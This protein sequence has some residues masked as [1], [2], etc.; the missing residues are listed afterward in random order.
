MKKHV[1]LVF[2]IILLLFLGACT[3]EKTTATNELD[4]IELE[5]ALDKQKLTANN[6]VDATVTI[7]NHNKTKK[8]IY[9]PTPKDTEEGI[10]AV[11]MTK[12]NEG[13]QLLDP[14]DSQDIPNIKERTYYDFV[15]VELDADE[16]IEQHYQWDKE[17]FDQESEK[18]VKAEKGDYI[19]S[20]FVILDELTEQKEHYEPEKQLVSKFTFSWGN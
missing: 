20:S 6:D 11:T 7:T 14:I 9:V 5:L 16:T 17:L 2:I 1:L 4:G 13:L 10:A 12:K 3:S 19:L 18:N 15:L 8:T